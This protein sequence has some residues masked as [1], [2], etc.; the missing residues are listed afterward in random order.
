MTLLSM[1]DLQD[2]ELLP[3]REALQSIDIDFNPT[4][5]AEAE[6]GEGDADAHATQVAIVKAEL[7]E[8]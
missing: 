1:L 7:E 6:T 4:N 2:V 3:A 5:V 8:D